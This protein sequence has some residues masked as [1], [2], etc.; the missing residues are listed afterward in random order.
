MRRAGLS[1]A[2]ILLCAVGSMGAPRADSTAASSPVADRHADASPMP[3]IALET[4][5][6]SLR[7]ALAQPLVV[8]RPGIRMFTSIVDTN[9]VRTVVLPPPTATPPLEK[10]EVLSGP[11]PLGLRNPWGT[12]SAAAVMIVSGTAAAY[13]KDRANKAF[14][15]YNRTQSPSALAT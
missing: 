6:L 3:L 4:A 10:P 13:F 12:F 8:D 15:E 9:S 11:G 5:P 14:N 2:G 1:I 7:L